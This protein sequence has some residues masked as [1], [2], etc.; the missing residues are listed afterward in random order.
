[1]SKSLS[2]LS[3]G[4]KYSL[5][6]GIGSSINNSLSSA[7][8]YISSKINLTDYLSSYMV[9]PKISSSFSPEFIEFNNNITLLSD[10]GLNTLSTT[11]IVYVYDRI[12]NRPATRLYLYEEDIRNRFADLWVRFNTYG[13]TRYIRDPLV[14]FDF[15]RNYSLL[16]LVGIDYGFF[17]E[18][19]HL[20]EG[21]RVAWSS[22]RRFLEYS[23]YY[24][25]F[26]LT[27][28][29]INN[30]FYDDVQ[31]RNLDN[32]EI[33]ARYHEILRDIDSLVYR[34]RLRIYTLLQVT[35]ELSHTF[36]TYDIIAN[37]P[38]EGNPLTIA[39]HN[40]LTGDDDWASG[41]LH[42]LDQRF[43]RLNR[44]IVRNLAELCELESILQS[45]PN[46]R[47]CFRSEMD[48]MRFYFS[49]RRD[50]H[51]MYRLL[52]VYRVFP[53]LARRYSYFDLLDL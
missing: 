12:I 29:N 24:M 42:N 27:R 48:Q 4:F 46:F 45:D 8:D 13:P 21:N 43:R 33:R 37:S 5:G 14:D 10:L 49:D 50:L 26:N 28:R 11:V 32:L 52:V 36:N 15:Y 35:E 39:Y 47:P 1:M 16:P 53:D 25:S 41:S 51:S 30:R 2:Y 19:L 18:P 17:A 6:S 38:Y 34:T 31:P 23:D 9:D 22:F 40:I 7:K 3:E 20:I 44:E